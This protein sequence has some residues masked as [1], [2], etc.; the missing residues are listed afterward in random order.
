MEDLKTPEGQFKINW[1]LILLLDD[2]YVDRYV[3]IMDSLSD[4]WHFSKILQKWFIK[5]VSNRYE[6]IVSTQLKQNPISYFL[7]I[8]YIS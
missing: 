4:T 7:S 3:L 2:S 5:T 6:Q 8:Q 1:P